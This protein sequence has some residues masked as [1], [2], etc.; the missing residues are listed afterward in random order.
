M[1]TFRDVSEPVSTG[2]SA[3]PKSEQPDVVTFD[4]K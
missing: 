2:A 3:I 4:L 1:V